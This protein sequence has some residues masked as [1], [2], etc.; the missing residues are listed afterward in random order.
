MTRNKPIKFTI[1][2]LMFY[3]N[4]THIEAYITTNIFNSKITHFL[5]AFNNI[6][7]YT[8]NLHYFKVIRIHNKKPTK[9][10]IHVNHQDESQM[11]SI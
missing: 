5:I 8:Y 9:E 10:T 7:T 11:E 3:N 4:G 2:K 1:Q 6:G